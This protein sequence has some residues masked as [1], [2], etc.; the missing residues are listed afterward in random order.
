MGESIVTYDGCIL[1]AGEGR[2]RLRPA[3][4]RV[5]GRI[6]SF[7]VK[8][9]SGAPQP[10]YLPSDTLGTFGCPY[11]CTA[12]GEMCYGWVD[13]HV[14]ILSLLVHLGGFRRL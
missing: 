6:V 10:P 11:G 13:T 12:Q 14:P 1:P 8:S 3:E 2:D 5:A 9:A 7:L 4:V